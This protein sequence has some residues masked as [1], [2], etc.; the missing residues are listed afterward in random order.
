VLRRIFGGQNA[1]E[2]IRNTY[3][4]YRN[5]MLVDR[6]MEERL[7]PLPLG[8]AI[9]HQ[10]VK[11]IRDYLT[12]TRLRLASAIAVDWGIDPDRL[13]RLR[14]LDFFLVLHRAEALA[15]RHGWVMPLNNLS[16]WWP[17]LRGRDVEKCLRDAPTMDDDPDLSH[18]M[19]RRL[20]LEVIHH[21]R[22]NVAIEYRRAVDENARSLWV[23]FYLR[24]FIE[25]WP[26]AEA[27]AFAARWLMPSAFMPSA[28]PR[29]DADLLE[30][31]RSFLRDWEV[32]ESKGKCGDTTCRLCG[33]DLTPGAAP[34]DSDEGSTMPGQGGSHL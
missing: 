30:A 25:G 26:T 17:R 32:W 34:V 19:R 11:W 16:P 7:D 18:K 8:E 1:D 28:A 2:A 10:D 24:E 29:S 33:M 13:H 9:A 5:G 4:M 22:A 27:D 12:T 6:L 23:A 31:V 3:M 14:P 15:E 20:L 21:R